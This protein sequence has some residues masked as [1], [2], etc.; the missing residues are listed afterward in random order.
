MA[1]FDVL[2]EP[3]IPVVFSDG[4]R[5]MLGIRDTLLR[6]HEIVHF[7]KGNILEEYGLYRFLTLFATSIFRPYAYID[8]LS[9]LEEGRISEEVINSYIQCC[10]DEG[11]SFDLFDEKRP[12][13]QATYNPQ[14]DV[15]PKTVLYLDLT[16]ETG[17]NPMYLNP[18]PEAE[19]S[20][21][22]DKALR[23]LIA[24][25][26][27]TVGAGQGYK[28]GMHNGSPLFLLPKRKNLFE[29]LVY[30]MPCLGKDDSKEFWRDTEEIVPDAPVSHI[31]IL[32]GMLF[33]VRRIVL[34]PSSDEEVVRQIY[35]SMGRRIT[36]EI[37]E[38]NAYPDWYLT[39]FMDKN[40]KWKYVMASSEKSLWRNVGSLYNG[41]KSSNRYYN[42]ILSQYHKCLL[43]SDEYHI[44]FYLFGVVNDQASFLE[45][46]KG[47]IDL[48]RRILAHEE[49]IAAI[50]KMVELMDKDG[51]KL[52]ELLKRFTVALN[53]SYGKNISWHLPTE[54]VSRYYANCEALFFRFAEKLATLPCT[55]SLSFDSVLD[56]FE[57][58]LH[59]EKQNGIKEFR[60]LACTTMKQMVAVETVLAKEYKKK[61]KGIVPKG[62]KKLDVLQVN[63]YDDKINVLSFLQSVSAKA[64]S[65]NGFCARLRRSLGFSLA[66]APGNA[67][68]DFYSLKPCCHSE[69]ED[70]FFF[71][72]CLQCL[73]DVNELSHA[74]PLE[75]VSLP[76]VD[77]ESF[78]NRLVQLL[79][80]PFDN[81][82]Y[83][84]KR[85]SYFARYC[86]SKGIVIDCTCL[87]YD[88][89][90]WDD[91][92]RKVQRKYARLLAYNLV[93]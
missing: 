86:K 36:K 88:F 89:L 10:K 23:S 54:I 66:E 74:V 18:V 80:M 53:F 11:V 31:G 65:D 58:E 51:D 44:G 39:Y 50:E 8:I 28:S 78:I 83:F 73:W 77:K 27:F 21:P 70:K 48:D 25:Y 34:L 20:L 5:D 79:D 41:I 69:N 55:E 84:I 2:N 35:F 24:C 47:E 1:H 38:S 75:T 61:E 90:D 82:G 71:C 67:L 40:N 13:L 29:T 37:R 85:F 30:S 81:G 4:H 33:P 9:V 92:S 93:G 22:Y 6:S 76:A 68:I 16:A 3:W 62:V 7:T 32:Q 63:M 64:D 14:Y 52:R 87:L 26:V 42:K 43:S 59:I 19:G 49:R 60:K 57:K 56:D 45:A 46:Q 91:P 12:F 17:N 72:A 15:K